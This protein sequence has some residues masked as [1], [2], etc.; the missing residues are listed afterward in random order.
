MIVTLSLSVD[1]CGRSW[2]PL[3]GTS[4]TCVAVYHHVRTMQHT[5]DGCYNCVQLALDVAS[6]EMRIVTFAV[7]V[8]PMPVAFHLVDHLPYCT[9]CNILIARANTVQQHRSG[10]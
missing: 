5:Y 3:T 4:C 2:E 1:G 7:R 10:V 6:P 9:R 8:W